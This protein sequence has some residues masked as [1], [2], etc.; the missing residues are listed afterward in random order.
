MAAVAVPIP[1]STPAVVAADPNGMNLHSQSPSSTS[2]AVY[3]TLIQTY[4]NLLC[5]DNALFL[6]ERNAAAFPQSENAIYL[7]AYCH[8]RNGSPKS[9]RSILIHRW[10]GGKINDLAATSMGSGGH[11]NNN[12]T[13][14]Q[15]LLE[16]T[17]S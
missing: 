13:S 12:N 5:Y 2:E 6:A 15:L 14:L 7:L 9:A 4:L 1:F 10:A 17:R 8:Y 3:T 16:R 11:D